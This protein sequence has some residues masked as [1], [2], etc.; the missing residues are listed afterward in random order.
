MTEAMIE[1]LKAY[2]E[3]G[4][5]YMIMPDHVPGI[6]GPAPG[7]VAFGY[8]FGYVRAAM[9]ALGIQDEASG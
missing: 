3:V 7:D 2:R 8:C 5:E 9:Q 1:A 6:S 4:Y